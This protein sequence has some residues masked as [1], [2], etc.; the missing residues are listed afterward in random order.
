METREVQVRPLSPEPLRAL[1]DPADWSRLGEGLGLAR[2]LLS[3]RE[4]WNVNSTATGGGVAEMLWSWVGLARGSGISMRWMTILRTPEFF[5]LTKRLHSRLHGED[6]DGGELGASER[7]LYEQVSR[8]NAE[9]VLA[10]TGPRDVVFLHDPQT[11]GLIPHLARTGRTVVWRCHIGTDEANEYSRTGWEFL[12]P[13][14]DGADAHVFYRDSYVP[15]CCRGL[16]TA[17]VLPAIDALS[18]KNQDLE[19]VQVEAILRRTGLLAGDRGDAG[20]AVFTRSTGGTGK[21]ERRCEMVTDG[22]LPEIDTPLVVQVSRWDRLKDAVGVI[23]GFAAAAPDDAHLVLAGPSPGSLSGSGPVLRDC[24]DA[25]GALATTVRSRVHLACIPVEDREENA[26]IVN[27]L[28]RQASVVVQKSLKEGF[29][30]TVTEAMWKRRPVIASATGGIH[31]QI[32]DGATG[33][34]LRDPRDLEAFGE[35]LAGL[36]AD[37]D[38]ARRI[39][40]AARESVRRSFLVNRP[41]L[42]YVDLLGRLASG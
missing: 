27:G 10:A 30:L 1:I 8:V 34:L 32:R 17:L 36:L 18:A 39:G 15:A 33:V 6:G 25:W 16:P 14:L 5:T 40:A 9:A 13:Y 3:G 19:R 42:Q 23:G 4:L 28:Q 29:G 20:A 21:V 26:A 37:P 7:E 41:A 11:T 12:A 35:A 38:R 31:N 22:F 24:R 2:S